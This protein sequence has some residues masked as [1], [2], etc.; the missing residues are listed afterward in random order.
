MKLHYFY[1]DLNF[2]IVSIVAMNRMYMQFSNTKPYL[3]EGISVTYKLFFSPQIN[4]T[5][6]GEIDS[7]KFNDFWS[8]NIK[9][10]RLQIER[11]I[12]NASVNPS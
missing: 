2:E 6:V 8:N 10:P 7:P 5:N 12:Y 9:I 1:A 11:G 4:V 3:N